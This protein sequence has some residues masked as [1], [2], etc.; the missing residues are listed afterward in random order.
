ML[1]PATTTSQC[2]CDGGWGSSTPNGCTI[3][4]PASPGYACQC[5]LILSLGRAKCFGNEVACIDSN[6]EYCEN[7]DTSKASCLQAV[8]SNCLGY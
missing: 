3:T 6:S 1:A 5:Y 8:G 2:L 7:P 4:I